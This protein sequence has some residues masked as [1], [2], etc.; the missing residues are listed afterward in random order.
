MYHFTT[1]SLENCSPMT[2]PP[3]IS[4][5]SLGG[6]PEFAEHA[7]GARALGRAM[8][9]AGLPSRLIEDRAGYIPEDA[10][11]TFVDQLGRGVGDENI[12]LL[13]AP[14]LT[15]RDYGVWGDHVLCAPTLG[16][17]L[18]WAQ[19]AM[20]FHSSADRTTWHADTEHLYYSYNFGLKQHPAYPAIA[21]SALGSVLSI[22][23]HY[24]GS[25][26]RPACIKCDFTH[27]G[28]SEAA[29]E[30][31]GCPIYWDSD[32]LEIG[33]DRRLLKQRKHGGYGRVIT[34]E[35]VRRDRSKLM[36]RNM[37][38]LVSLMLHL[39]S[40]SDRKSLE[41]I[42]EDLDLGPRTVQRRLAQEDTSFREVMKLHSIQR[43][44][45]LLAH[46]GL[47][48]TQIATEIGFTSQ[49]NFSRAFR[50]QVGL[51]PSEFAQNCKPAFPR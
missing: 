32:R 2:L 47:S 27:S 11:A 48:V 22:F 44:K 13:W 10:L 18:T 29:E 37:S 6:M 5:R 42:A 9:Q 40:D 3:L 41:S 25:G 15:V 38:D 12:G 34:I 45:E 30:V 36:P 19:S 7:I 33:F 16:E 39:R 23:R 20:P 14:A 49:S 43:A 28:H 35:D 26:F 46:G 51:S 1:A 4:A 21:Y 24:L 17:A 31:F 8:A 50:K